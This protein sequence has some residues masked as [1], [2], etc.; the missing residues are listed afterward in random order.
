ADPNWRE[1]KK[2]EQ[3]T[4]LVTDKDK[5]EYE[6]KVDLNLWDKY[7]TGDSV[8]AQKTAAGGLT[9]TPAK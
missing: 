2:T 7:N 1:G 5:K 6:V 3:Y 4:F 8:P 9:I